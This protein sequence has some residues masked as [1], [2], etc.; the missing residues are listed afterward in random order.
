M[1]AWIGTVALV[2]AL[3]CGQV[4]AGDGNQLLS[5]CQVVIKFIDGDKN[6]DPFDVGYCTGIV[7]GVEGALFILNDSL[8]ARMQTCYPTAGINNGQKARIVVKFLLENPNKLQMPAAGLAML[9][10]KAAYPCK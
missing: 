6:V 1:K 10:Y 7:E 2:T 3:G 5:T 8:P 9:A 4:M